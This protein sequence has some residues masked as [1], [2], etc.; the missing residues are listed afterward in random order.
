MY[1][2]GEGTAPSA[3]LAAHYYK[4]AIKKGI[5]EA[6]Y[7]LAVTHRQQGNLRWATFWLR[8]AREM[9]DPDAAEALAN[10]GW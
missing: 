4:L 5:P 8:R 1:D 2:A 9:G 10:G 3:K 6:A 7:N